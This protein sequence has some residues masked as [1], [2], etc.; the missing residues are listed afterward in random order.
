[1]ELV[2]EVGWLVGE[3]VRARMKARTRWTKEEQRLFSTVYLKM[4]KSTNK[5]THATTFGNKKGNERD[6]SEWI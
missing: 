2:A 1:M 6:Q 3:M 5:K 4:T